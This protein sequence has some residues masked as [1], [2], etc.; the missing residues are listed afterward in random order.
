MS[1]VVRV[2][3]VDRVLRPRNYQTRFDFATWLDSVAQILQLPSRDAM[4]VVVFPAHI[5]SPLFLSDEWAAVVKSETIAEAMS[6]A[7]MDEKVLLLR[8]AATSPKAERGRRIA[9]AFLDRKA[10]EAAEIYRWVFSEFA[11]RYNVAVV[12]G[13]IALPG[14]KVIEN[15][16]QVEIKAPWNEVG[17]VFAPNGQII[18]DLYDSSENQP[19]AKSIFNL[20]P[21]KGRMV[22][23]T[24]GDTAIGAT[25]DQPRGSIPGRGVWA[26]PSTG[27]FA[28]SGPEIIVAPALGGQL[29]EYEFPG[30][31]TIG[32]VGSPAYPA[33]ICGVELSGGS[34]RFLEGTT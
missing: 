23:F 1:G 9:N 19:W 13:S 24:V 28:V 26:I 32:G 3:A 4:T 7:L 33:G 18:S 17:A 8:H 15:E 12:A 25:L 6:W 5:G 34:A 2:W 30:G 11:A 16:I 27:R 29:W 31:V 10:K 21:G 14:A 20:S 22:T